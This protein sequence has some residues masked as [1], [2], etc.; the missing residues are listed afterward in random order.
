MA[1][2]LRRLSTAY[3]GKEAR[4]P[5][6]RSKGL[7]QEQGDQFGLP[8][9]TGDPAWQ[10]DNKLN[11]VVDSG[12]CP[13]P[14]K[15]AKMT[16]RKRSRSPGEDRPS[17]G[18]ILRMPWLGAKHGQWQGDDLLHGDRWTKAT[19]SSERTL[20]IFVSI[21]DTQGREYTFANAFDRMGKV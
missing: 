9:S 1:S 6:R 16:G 11:R 7:V 20:V 5:H 21:E 4:S 12:A 13:R 18:F 10:N 3:Q 17:D 19:G 8:T 14:P 2:F 15:A